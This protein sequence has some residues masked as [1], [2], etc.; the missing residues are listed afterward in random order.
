MRGDTDLDRPLIS[1]IVPAWNAEKYLSE[2]LESIFDQ[3]Y[4]PIE[5]IVV[6]D[7]STDRTAEVMARY[8]GRI[9]GLHQKNGGPAAARNAGLRA[10]TGSFLAFLD[11]DD[12]WLP[13]KTQRQ[14]DFLLANPE[15]GACVTHIRNFWIP[16]LREEAEA[17]KDHAIA[18]PLPGF[19][20]QTLMM[21]RETFEKVGYLDGSAGAGDA[22]DWF[23]RASDAGVKCELLSECLVLRR[24]HHTNRSRDLGAL[25]KTV[26]LKFLKDSLD[27]RR[28]EAAA[29]RAD[30]AGNQPRAKGDRS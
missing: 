28:R 26:I 27:R 14:V 9:R 12:L 17:H 15:V 10:A 7:G 25:P 5:I 18:K 3:T 29:D 19:L 22:T 24:L 1:A 16:E 13:D 8:E 11:A 2:A 30:D 21:R 20:T 4:A 6:N 23:L